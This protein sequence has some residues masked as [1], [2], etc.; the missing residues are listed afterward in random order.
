MIIAMLIAEH[1]TVELVGHVRDLYQKRVPDVR[2]LIPVI[3]GLEKHEVLLALPKLVKLNPPV[4]KGV[5]NR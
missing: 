2:F 4:V 5:F 1:P 3:N